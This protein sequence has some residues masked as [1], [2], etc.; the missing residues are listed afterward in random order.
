MVGHLLRGLWFGCTVAAVSWV[1]LGLFADYLN[2]CG[3]ERA[4]LPVAGRGVVCVQA[5][6]WS[7]RP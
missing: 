5:T 2:M 3:N 1:L 7:P 6:N 4:A